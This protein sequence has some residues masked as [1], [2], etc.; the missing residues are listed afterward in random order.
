VRA[1]IGWLLRLLAD[2]IDR[3]GAPRYM[4]YSFT[5]ERGQGIRFREGG[6]GC[7]LWYS[8]RADYAR[9]YDEAEAPL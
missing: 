4:S 7:P 9:A 3:D 5:F 6:R 1:R 8:G 2:R